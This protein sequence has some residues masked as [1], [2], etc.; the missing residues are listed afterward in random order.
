MS[1][2]NDGGPAYPQQLSDGQRERGCSAD[3][4]YGG[5]SLR[6][7]FAGQAL[8]GYVAHNPESLDVD[9]ACVAYS[10]ADAML[11]RWQRS[12]ETTVI[13]ATKPKRKYTEPTKDGWIIRCM[14]AEHTVRQQDKQLK[15][16]RDMVKL[17]QE[18]LQNALADACMLRARDG[19][20]TSAV[21]V[22]AVLVIVLVIVLIGGAQ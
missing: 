19:K 22:L 11:G 10:T 18:Q 7:W 12:E 1:G 15:E 20:L 6:D 5:M 8:A 16:E 21:S 14:A 17:L 3:F 9:L 2:L 4:G 13:A